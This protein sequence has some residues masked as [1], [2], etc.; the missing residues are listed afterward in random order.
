VDAI[1]PIEGASWAQTDLASLGAKHVDDEV[2]D[3]GDRRPDR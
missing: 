2:C 1:D 3:G